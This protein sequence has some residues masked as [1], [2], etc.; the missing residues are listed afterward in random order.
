MN[1]YVKYAVL[2]FGVILIALGLG[3]WYFQKAPPVVA[4]PEVVLQSEQAAPAP[5]E[6]ITPAVAGPVNPITTEQ[7]AGAGLP[8]LAVSDTAMR[9]AMATLFSEAQLVQYFYLNDIIRRLVVT[10][11]NLPREIVAARLLPLRP[12]TGQFLVQEN[13]QSITLDPANFQR[14]TPYVDLLQNLDSAKLV[15]IY[16]YFYPLFQQQYQELGYPD[17]YFNDRLIAVLDYLIA[18]TAPTEPLRLVQQHVLYQYADPDLEKMSAGGKLLTRIGN[19]NATKLK[20][21]LRELR[22]ALVAK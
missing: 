7:N 16:K 19:D 20:A 12:V 5:V 9:K 21:R 4:P 14:Y 13:D 8:A 17:G 10:I 6:K 2:L 22:A 11:D 1:L 15:A 18:F 3:N